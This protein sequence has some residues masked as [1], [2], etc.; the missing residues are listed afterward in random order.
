M[1][2]WRFI[3]GVPS[4]PMIFTDRSK[5]VKQYVDLVQGWS[6][7]QCSGDDGH[8]LPLPTEESFDSY[9]VGWLDCPECDGGWEASEVGHDDDDLYFY[10]GVDVE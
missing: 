4:D 8:E 2:F 10:D 6:P 7:L 1:L 3:L 5:A 9:F